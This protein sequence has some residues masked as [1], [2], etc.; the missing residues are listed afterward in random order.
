MKNW[1]IGRKLINVICTNCQRT[2]RKT[3][4]EYNRSEKNNKKHY[5]VKK[6]LYQEK[7][8]T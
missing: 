6:I 7:E 4:S 5:L 8:T 3:E 1:K 2:F